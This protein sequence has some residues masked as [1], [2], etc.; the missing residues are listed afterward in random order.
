M[1]RD[2]AD[3][4]FSIFIRLRDSDDNG[5]VK[6]CTCGKYHD[7]KRVDTGH[8]LKRQHMATRFNEVNCAAQCKGCNCFEQGQSAKHRDYI[9]QKYGQQKLDLL[10]ASFRNHFHFTEFEIKELSKIYKVKAKEEAKKRG[11]NL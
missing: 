1:K 2:I 7:W 6:C 3:K 5:I 9:L 8:Y 4:W 11:I 10:E